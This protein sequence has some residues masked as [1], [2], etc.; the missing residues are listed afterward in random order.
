MEN[1]NAYFKL[2]FIIGPLVMVVAGLLGLKALRSTVSPD[3]LAYSVP[4]TFVDGQTLTAAQLNSVNNTAANA[5]NGH[6]HSG[7][8]GEGTSL[9]FSSATNPFTASGDITFNTATSSLECDGT[10]AT[11][12]LLDQGN[13]GV[14]I[15]DGNS[16]TSEDVIIRAGSG[17]ASLVFRAGNSASTQWELKLDNADSDNLE[18]NY[19]GVGSTEVGITTGGAIWTDSGL[20]TNAI[21]W[22]TYSGTTCTPA[23]CTTSVDTTAPG[24]GRPLSFSCM[25]GNT[26]GD[27]DATGLGGDASTSYDSSLDDL[28]LLVS[29]STYASKSYSCVAFYK[30]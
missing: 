8:D 17:D 2:G 1:R 10:T 21:A 30:P 11:D 20:A 28:E 24:S 3:L 25:V 4:V 5:F 12:L 27:F 23:P 13:F 22:E 14:V 9:G 19:P 29:T 15:G 16:T 18:L 6:D 26:G 7:A